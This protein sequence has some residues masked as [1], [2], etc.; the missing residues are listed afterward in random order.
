ML[1][2]GEQ[3]LHLQVSTAMRDLSWVVMGQACWGLVGEVGCWSTGRSTPSD[4]ASF[5]GSSR[6][7]HGVR[8]HGRGSKMNGWAPTA[9]CR[10]YDYEPQEVREALLPPE[11]RREPG[12]PRYGRPP[13]IDH[14]VPGRWYWS[15]PLWSA[16]ASFVR[17]CV[18]GAELRMRTAHHALL[19]CAAARHRRDM[20]RQ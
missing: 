8:A 19:P 12:E 7:S 16:K 6:S 11:A 14:Q 17:M 5:A 10:A 9:T 13:C 20:H 3:G 15:L 4:A 1:G 2:W 18:R